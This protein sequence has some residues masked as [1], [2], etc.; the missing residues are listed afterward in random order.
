MLKY[1]VICKCFGM[2]LL[3]VVIPL[4]NK[5][6]RCSVSVVQNEGW[7]GEKRIGR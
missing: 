2:L 6:N 4:R 5:T 1:A 7:R 3:L